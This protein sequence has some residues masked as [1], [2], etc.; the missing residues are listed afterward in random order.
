MPFNPDFLSRTVAL[1]DFMRF[2][3]PCGRIKDRVPH[4]SR[5]WRRVG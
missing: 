3:A 4:P 2:N 1:M 5:C